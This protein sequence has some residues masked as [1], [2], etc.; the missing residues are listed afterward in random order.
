MAKKNTT[1]TDT[2]SALPKVTSASNAGTHRRG[3]NKSA[4]ETATAASAESAGRHRKA[5]P[6]KSPVQP[7]VAAVAVP[8]EET[9]VASFTV[10]PVAAPEPAPS[11]QAH[12]PISITREDIARLAFLYF[13]QRGYQGGSPDQ[14]WLRAEEELLELAG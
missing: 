8:V 1:S 13:E 10:Q 11:T 9:P 6:A 14:D 7:E 2:K 4:A 3:A 5:T 12:S